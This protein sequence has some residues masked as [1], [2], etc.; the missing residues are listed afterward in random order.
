MVARHAKALCVVLVLLLKT[1]CAAA[2]VDA[3]VDAMYVCM[4]VCMFVRACMYVWRKHL[5]LYLVE[6]FATLFLSLCFEEKTTGVT[7]THYT[8]VP[9]LVCVWH[10]LVI[11]WTLPSSINLER[12]ID[13]SIINKQKTK[14]RQCVSLMFWGMLR[15]QGRWACWSCV[16]AC[17]SLCVGT[18]ACVCM[19]V[20]VHPYIQYHHRCFSFG[21]C[22]L[23]FAWT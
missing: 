1:H 11:R 3:N 13:W 8:A 14:F 5:Y 7:H 20:C 4:F 15:T 18:C 21:V 16:R 17:L 22:A 23:Y 19:C 10:K 12:K 6:R 2:N 9:V